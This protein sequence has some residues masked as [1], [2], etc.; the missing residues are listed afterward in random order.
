MSWCS[1]L[2]LIGWVTS[3]IAVTSPKGAVSV[4]CADVTGGAEDFTH[5]FGEVQAVGV[6]CAVFLDGQR[7]G[8]DALRGGLGDEPEGRMVTAGEVNAGNLQIASIN[9]A[10]VQCDVSIE[11]DALVG[12][13]AHGVVAFL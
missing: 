4:G 3:P 11:G 8:G 10:L 7:T 5:V 12:A 9:I 13:A 1:P 2:Q 6:P